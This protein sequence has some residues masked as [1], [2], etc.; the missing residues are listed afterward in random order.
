M[1][2]GCCQDL[3]LSLLVVSQNVMG[4]RPR[5]GNAVAIVG[6]GHP[7]GEVLVHVQYLS[8]SGE[9]DVDDELKAFLLEVV[10]VG[11]GHVEQVGRDLDRGTSPCSFSISQMKS[12]NS[13]SFS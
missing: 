10:H 7:E 8:R 9:W 3:E 2:F 11:Q 5:D 13:V 1:K 12:D 6:H 4:S